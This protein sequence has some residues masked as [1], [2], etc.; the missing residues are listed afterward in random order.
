MT[1]LK[2][3]EEVRKRFH[4]AKDFAAGSLIFLIAARAPASSPLETLE[5][6]SLIAAASPSL[7]L[8][9]RRG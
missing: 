6:T 4:S 7:I 3:T 8:K 5:M 2:S 9:D 1:S